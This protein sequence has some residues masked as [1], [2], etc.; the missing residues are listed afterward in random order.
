[1]TAPEWEPVDAPTAD[2]LSLIADADTAGEEWV[3]FR[4]ILRFV[5]EHDGQVSPNAV[6]EYTDGIKPARVGSFYRRALLEGLIRWDGAWETSNDTR[7]RNG[8]KPVRVYVLG[9]AS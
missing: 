3:E 8:G 5:A 1:M 6:R 4:R 2:L 9:E 7:Q